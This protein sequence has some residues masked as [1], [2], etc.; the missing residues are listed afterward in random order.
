M[1]LDGAELCNG[2]L[3][4][5]VG[6]KISDHRAIDARD[7]VPLS[8]LADGVFSRIDLKLSNKNVFDAVDDTLSDSVEAITDKNLLDAV[9]ESYL[10]QLIL[11]SHLII[12]P[13]GILFVDEL[14]A[15]V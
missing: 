11:L 6:I 14:F 1:T 9:Y 7:G 12:V 10:T 4:L 13:L 15:Y 5:T 2:L 8:S 3:H